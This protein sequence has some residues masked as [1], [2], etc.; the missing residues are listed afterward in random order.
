MKKQK[1]PPG[2]Y[3]KNG[4]WHYRY[5]ER[6]LLPG[7]LVRQV[8]RSQK[9]TDLE[10]CPKLADVLQQYHESAARLSKRQLKP[11]SIMTMSEFWRNNY[12]PWIQLSKKPSTQKDYR[13][14][15]A[16]HL[17]QSTGDIPLRD[18]AKRDAIAALEVI[19]Y[20]KKLSQSIV[21]HARTVLGSMFKRA[22]ELQLVEHSPVRDF[23]TPKGKPATKGPAYTTEEAEVIIRLLTGRAE[24]I[25]A[26]LTYAGIRPQELSGLQWADYDGELLHIRR[27]VWRGK[28]VSVKTEESAAVIPVIQPLREVLDNWKPTTAGVGWL[29]CGNTGNPV[30]LGCVARR[31]VVPVLKANGIPWKTWYGFRRGVGT[32][33]SDDMNLGEDSVRAILRHAP[34]SDTAREH[35][36]VRELRKRQAAMNQYEDHILKVRESLDKSPHAVV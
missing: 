20:E 19:A 15:W 28:V 21:H 11:T 31:E 4:A 25:V 23:Q 30:D 34:D 24:V 27:A 29:V 18:F 10:K 7:N 6:T 9:L 35:Y 13:D 8:R 2:L 12:W 17:E 33:M 1:L 5:Y 14:T 26:L 16:R 3:Q 36:I 32:T 22:C